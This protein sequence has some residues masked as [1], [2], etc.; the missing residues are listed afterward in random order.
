MNIFLTFPSLYRKI[1]IPLFIHQKSVRMPYNPDIHHRRSIRLKEYD[2][3]L[4]GFYFVT[5]CVNGRLPLFGRIVDD[6]MHLN[7]AG[8]I[9]EEQFCLLPQRYSHIICREYMIMPNHFHCIIQIMDVK[10]VQ[11]DSVPVG[12][13]LVGAQT[14]NQFSGQPQGIAPT[15]VRPTLGEIVG[16][17]KSVTTNEYIRGVKDKGWQPFDTRLWQRNYYEHIIRDQRSYDEISCYILDNPRYWRTD[18]LHCVS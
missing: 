7:E 2:Y 4:D 13:P 12:A 9:I 14:I 18:K 8:I 17:F 1:S 3:S 5:I 10:D 11:L 15:G 6:V 16:A